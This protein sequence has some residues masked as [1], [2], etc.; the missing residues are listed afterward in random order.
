VPTPDVGIPNKKS[1]ASVL[2]KFL[3]RRPF[4]ALGRLSFSLYLVHWPIVLGV[5][6]A[7][8]IAV[9]RGEDGALAR[10]AAVAAALG[11]S[12]ACAELFS[13]VDAWA[14]SASRRLRGC[15]DVRGRR[16]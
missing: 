6:S 12:L 2:A 5:G 8:L 9:G 1:R 7:V 14:I 3:D 16:R 15:G 4:V 11:L 10:D 13:S